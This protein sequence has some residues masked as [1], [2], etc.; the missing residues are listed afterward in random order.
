MC[1]NEF[2][3]KSSDDT[4]LIWKSYSRVYKIYAEMKVF[5]KLKI[6]RNGLLMEK[7][8]LGI[9]GYGQQGGFYG[10]LLKDGRVDGMVLGAVAEINEQVD[11]KIRGDFP[12]VKI[13]RDY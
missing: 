13:Y 8:R 12:E 3:D 7:V 6:E 11:E 9:I 1:Y 4:F 2:V 10:S 5:A